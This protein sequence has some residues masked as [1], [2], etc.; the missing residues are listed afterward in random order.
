MD[1]KHWGGNERETG[2]GDENSGINDD[3]LYNLETSHPISVFFV[4]CCF[5]YFFDFFKK[6][7]MSRFFS[8]NQKSLAKL[9]FQQNKE[10]IQATSVSTV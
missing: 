6:T 2:D 4:F 10:K 8:Q 3:R 9:V 7:K 1:Q 5:S